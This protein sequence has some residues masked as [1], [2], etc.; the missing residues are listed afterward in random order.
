VEADLADALEDLKIDP[1]DLVAEEK[2]DLE[3]V[4]ADSEEGLLKCMMLSA[5]SASSHAKF[6]SGQQETSRFS[7]AIALEMKTAQVQ[8]QALV[9]EETDLLHQAR[10]CLRS[11]SGRLMKN[12]IK[13]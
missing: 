3:I 10:E 4:P 13:L 11:N 5:A 2:V 1:A 6:R 9:Q 12:L 7:A 8:V